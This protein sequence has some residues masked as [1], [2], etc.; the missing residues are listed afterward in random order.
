MS[1]MSSPRP[2]IR[3]AVL[4]AVG[5]G[6]D[7]LPFIHIAH[8]LARRGVDT[9]LLAP[10]RYRS[11]ADPALIRFD[12]VGAEEVFA[13][14][15]DSGDI[16]HPT[17]GLGASWRYYGA[18]MRASLPRIRRWSPGDTVLIGSSFAMA[19]RL[20]EELDGFRNVTVHLS[21][22]LLWSAHA[23]ARWP[24]GSGVP[25]GWPL[26]LRR[27]CMDLAERALI[28]PTIAAQLNPYRAEL[29]LPPVRR[30]FS[31]QL[32]GGQLAY[33]SRHGLL[34]PHRT[35]RRKAGSPDS[36]CP[37]RRQTRYRRR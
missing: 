33:A 1:A 4:C 26:R 15:F 22:A 28:N 7:V 9:V 12:R 16:W 3:N 37:R 24:N 10:E 25:H 13:D 11:L 31:Q 32:H 36:C 34:L 21:P 2:P 6:G 20:A 5:S 19:T 17:K 30:I 14:V 35:G 29:G 27:W 18:A 23:P 8:A